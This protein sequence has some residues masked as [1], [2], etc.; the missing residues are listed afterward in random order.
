M[1]FEQRF[2]VAKLDDDLVHT[3]VYR[4]GRGGDT[5]HRFEYQDKCTVE[6]YQ[7]KKPS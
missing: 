1:L 5:V 3:K 4:Y 6:E 2:D 7:V